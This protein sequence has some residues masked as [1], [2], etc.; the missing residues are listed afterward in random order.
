MI[1]VAKNH[2][3]TSS[4]TVTGVETISFLANGAVEIDLITQVAIDGLV[5]ESLEEVSNVNVFY[6]TP[7]SEVL[8]SLPSEVIATLSD[9]TTVNVQVEWS[10]VSYNAYAT[11][12]YV[13]IGEVTLPAGVLNP[14]NLGYSIVASVNPINIQ[15]I[16]NPSEQDIPLNSTKEYAESILP[17]TVEITLEHPIDGINTITL[18]AN[19]DTSS[20]SPFDS[21]D[22]GETRMIGFPA[23]PGYI[24]NTNNFEVEALFNVII[25]YQDFVTIPSFTSPVTITDSVGSSLESGEVSGANDILVNGGATPG[26]FNNRLRPN[27]ISNRRFK[28]ASGRIYVGGNNVTT[29]MQVIAPLNGADNLSYYHL[30]IVGN[31]STSQ[32]GISGFNHLASA[33]GTTVRAEDIIIKDVY[34]AGIFINEGTAGEHYASIILKDVRVFGH[35]QD[36]ELIYIGHAF[37]KLVNYSPIHHLEIYNFYG[38]N[39]G[40]DGLQLTHVANGI[41]TICAMV[42][43][44]TIYDVGK[45]NVSQQ[46]LLAQI[47]NT[48]GYCKKYIFHKAPEPAN[49]FTHGFTFEDCYFEWDTDSPIY[50]GRL[51][52]SD[53]FGA[54]ALAGNGLPIT[55]RRC[56]FNPSVNQTRLARILETDCNI[57]F[58]DCYFS[59]RISSGV[60]ANMISDERGVSPSNTISNTGYTI[61]APLA[62]P[63]YT[64][65]D[66]AQEDTHGLCTSVFWVN[67]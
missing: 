12:D 46:R 52:A 5:I 63:T 19:W 42:E 15:S 44:G 10:I 51:K 1:Y 14:G 67:K 55:F 41:D 32:T 7:E 66:P 38:T 33:T 49:I 48:N 37:D 8:S 39:K 65:H 56:Y 30:G 13:V 59:N 60:L 57:V 2:I 6:S 18:N 23:Y 16:A 34:F 20:G 9:S 58:E 17:E 4:I 64:N 35:P 27:G 61:G 29:G 54:S 62:S 25:V 50:I 40:K 47:H 24:T 26:L 43:Y 31:S 45:A 36:G 21:S 28:S 3:I 22:V 53:A 11:G